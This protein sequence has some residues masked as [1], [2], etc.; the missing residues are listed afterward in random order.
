[1]NYKKLILWSIAGVMVILA[2]G[3]YFWSLRIGV[4]QLAGYEEKLANGPH[5]FLPIKE[6]DFGNIKQSG[7]I[8]KRSF[9]VIN[10]GTE[11]V[12]IDKVVTSCSCTTA[13]ISKSILRVGDSAILSVA[14]DP[15]YH[16][17]SYEQISRSVTIFSNAKNDPRPEVKVYATVEYDLGIDKT[18]Y[19]VDED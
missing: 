16:F 2:V 9:E 4:G 8:A 3:S 5:I 11:D 13:K 15:N 14:F 19:G 1:M 6:Y 18:K 12:V 10:N 17:E 7:P